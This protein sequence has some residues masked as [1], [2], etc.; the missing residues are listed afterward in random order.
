VCEDPISA[1][2]KL[3][4]RANQMETLAMV[5]YE[6]TTCGY[7]YDPAVGDPDSDI[8]PGTSFE[9]IPDDWSCPVC[10]AEKSQFIFVD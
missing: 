4:I 5:N 2:T 10:G 9:D 3:V 1:L 8:E 6:C 7:I